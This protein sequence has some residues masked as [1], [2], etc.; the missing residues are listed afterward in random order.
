MKPKPTA[1]HRLC[2]A[3]GVVCQRR[4]KGQNQRGP[5]KPGAELPGEIW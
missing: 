4:F 1:T 5:A 3:Y 2:D